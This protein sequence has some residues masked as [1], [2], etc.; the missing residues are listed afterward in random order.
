MIFAPRTRQIT[1]PAFYHY[2]LLICYCLD[3]VRLVS[4]LQLAI[5]AIDGDF[6]FCQRS[7]KSLLT[8]DKFQQELQEK[9]DI[10]LRQVDS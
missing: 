6:D 7:V 4:W 10:R 9:Y 1:T 2:V 8:D 3:F 5:A